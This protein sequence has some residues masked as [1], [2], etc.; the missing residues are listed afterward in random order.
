MPILTIMR[1]VLLT[2]GR[3]AV[4]RRSYEHPRMGRVSRELVVHPGAVAILPLLDGDRIVLIHNYRFTVGRE[5][6]E[7]PAGTLEPSEPPIVCAARELE[8]ETGY[9]AGRIE[10]IGEFFTSPGFTNERIWAFAAFELR[11]TAQ[12]LDPT[13]QIRTEIMPMAEALGATADGRIVDAKTIAVLHM[14]NQRKGQTR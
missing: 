1:E 5:L 13:E 11:A 12:K 8:E 9:A 10:P 6:L 14:F 2:T 3:F 7:I 4:E